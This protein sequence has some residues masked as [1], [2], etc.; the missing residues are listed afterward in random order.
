MTVGVSLVNDGHGR[1]Q[2]SIG[3]VILRQV[4]LGCMRRQASQLS[5]LT[6]WLLPLFRVPALTSISDGL[7]SGQINP[8][9]PSLINGV[10]HSTAKQI[11]TVTLQ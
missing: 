9:L 8:F 6:P 11:R 4:V 7:S 5:S 1:A 3:M 10:Y 2:P